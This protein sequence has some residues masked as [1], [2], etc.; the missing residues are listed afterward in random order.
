VA[1][2]GKPLQVKLIAGKLLDATIPTVVDPDC[3]GAVIDTSVGAATSTKPGWITNATGA[4]LL[5]GLKLASP[6]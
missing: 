2:V 1:S 6:V 4:V 5:L 3:P